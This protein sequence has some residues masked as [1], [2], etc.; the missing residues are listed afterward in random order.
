MLIVEPCPPPKINSNIP[1]QS[2]KV[3][4]T[5]ITFGTITFSQPPS[6]FERILFII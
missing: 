5:V 6:D 2:G 3:E 4:Y 1:V